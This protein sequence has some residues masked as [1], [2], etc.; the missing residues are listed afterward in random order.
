MSKYTSLLADIDRKLLFAER[1]IER[2]T[3]EY[4]KAEAESKAQ[5]EHLTVIEAA[6]KVIQSLA[7]ELQTSVKD[8]IVSTVQA[9]LDDTFPDVQFN[10]ELT[11]RRNQ[12]EMDVFVTD[13]EGNKQAI[14]DGC[15]GGI[16]DIISFALR[17]A[18]WSLDSGAAPVIMLDEPFKFLSEGHRNQGAELLHT[19]SRK[20]GIQFIVVSHV[21]EIVNRA[22]SVYMV[23][24]GADE[25]SVA[26]NLKNSY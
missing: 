18:V 12:T 10:M 7:T 6:V 19:L 2:Y 20:L 24:K 1:D 4:E 16:K 8:K 13:K 17:V 15:G 14:L 25:R 21:T 3:E 9:A 23:T 5:M 26:R 22:D 11:S